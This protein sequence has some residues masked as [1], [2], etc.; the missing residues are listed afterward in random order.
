MGAGTKQ[1]F[2]Q[3]TLQ[4]RI[5]ADAEQPSNF[6]QHGAGEL[7][8]YTTGANDAEYQCSRNVNRSERDRNR[9]NG[10]F[11]EYA[12]WH[13]DRGHRSDWQHRD[14]R[15]QRP[16]NHEFRIEQHGRG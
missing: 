2:R 13:C 14:R 3:H 8:H 11:S 7:Q 9:G 12:V 16:I 5:F 15:G 6:T 4:H 10:N 1:R